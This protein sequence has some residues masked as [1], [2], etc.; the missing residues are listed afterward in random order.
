MDVPSFSVCRNEFRRS[1]HQLA[2]ISVQCSVIGVGGCG[3]VHTMSYIVVA[4]DPARRRDQRCT[5]RRNCNP[6]RRRRLQSVPTLQFL[7]PISGTVHEPLVYCAWTVQPPTTRMDAAAANLIGPTDV[8]SFTLT[9]Q[10]PPPQVCATAYTSKLFTL[11]HG[12][13]YDSTSIRRR[14]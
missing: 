10:H 14:R 9:R 6:P 11:R 12:Y 13:N 4:S 1:L 5:Q 8:F 3:W 7:H 2:G